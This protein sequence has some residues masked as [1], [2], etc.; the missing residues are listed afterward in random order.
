MCFWR[1]LSPTLPRA[2]LLLREAG[3]LGA[4]DMSVE[5]AKRVDQELGDVAAFGPFRLFP[6]ARL[7]KR[8]DVPVE[9]GGRA[10][11]ILI[12]LVEEAGKVVSKADLLA[13]IWRDITVVEGV[14]RTHVCS[15][16][17]ALGDVA[18][19]TRYITSV[20]GRGYC[21]VAPVVRST[22][23]VTAETVV[24]A[25]SEGGKLS[26]S[27]PPRLG[28]MA[29]RDE[30]VRKL[31]E[32]LLEHRFVT[33]VGAAGIGKTTVAVS[34]GHALLDNFGG[35]VRF[36]ELGSIIDPN[37][38]AATVASTL[39][40]VV[41]TDDALPSLQAFL[42]DKRVLIVLDNCEHLVAAAATLSEHL[43]LHAPHVHLLATSREAL[44]V[45]GER[46]H[47][48]GPLETPSV[49]E[50]MSAEAV[51]TFPAVQVLLERAAAGGWFADLTDDDV[52]FVAQICNRLDGV[53]LALELGAS[54]VGEC[55]LRGTAAMLDDRSR[56]L[57][58]HGRRTAPPR[59]QTLHALIAWSYDRLSK[60]ECLV[61]RRLS[62]MVGAF[63]LDT[64]KAVVLDDGDPCESFPEVISGLVAKSL[65]SSSVE[66]GEVV[67][68]MLETTR[69]FAFER[70]D[71]SN[72]LQQ[73]SLRHAL[74]FEER[75]ARE[76]EGR[77]ATSH[78]QASD[79]GNVRAALV[80][81]FS[82]PSGTGA[83][84]RLAS[85]AAQVLLK[86]GLVSECHHWC[87]QALAVMAPPE[88]GTLIE[89]RLQE[90]LAHSAIFTRGLDSDAGTA[91]TRGLEL[92]RALG[93]GD[94]EIRLLGH[95][96]IFLIMAGDF[97]EGLEV[98]RQCE[99]VGSAS[100]AGVIIAQS[101]IGVAEGAC[102]NTLRSQEHC[103]ESLRRAVQFGK[104][105]SMPTAYTN[106]RLTLARTFWLR[107][108]PARAAALAR[109]V[110]SDSATLTHA[111]DKCLRLA[112][113]ETIFAWCG[114]WSEADRLLD[115]LAEHVERYSLASHRGMALGL[116]G[117]FLVK[118]DQPRQGCSLLR[119]AA[120]DLK[121]TKNTALDTRFASALAEGLAATGSIDE[122]LATVQ[123]ALELAQRRG[124]TWDG[125][126]LLRLK[127][128]LLASG[129]GKDPRAADETLARA[130]E[131]ARHQG[132]VAWE[133]RAA[134]EIAREKLRRG[135][136][137]NDLRD[138]AA[139]YARFTDGFQTPDLQA[140]HNLL[141]PH[142]RSDR[143]R[144]GSES[145]VVSF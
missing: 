115:M 127:G 21:F 133:L 103:E 8:D 123:A 70:L 86:L 25:T 26:P 23:E 37:L 108:Q 116:R 73:V 27:L 110:M 126:D 60:W 24:P 83:G 75:L 53:A 29:G 3:R 111:V 6:A 51:Q 114:E 5:A 30:T 84:V 138:L 18:S 49:Y 54:F 93:G 1:D 102:G 36:I 2:G 87:R 57:W 79:L 98:A 143:Q 33:V 119:N 15:L 72:E 45:E 4:K 38:V 20:A 91:L 112:Y 61:L 88:T 118:T 81:C 68:R 140:A 95:L 124:G 117:E 129:P 46:V 130:V 89:L 55:G 52:P 40:I 58:Q 13:S 120:A 77:E 121:V 7:L 12:A 62:V 94:N 134:T 90:A 105:R 64:A 28:R 11:D 9:L 42:R 22:R 17:K 135:G 67:Y 137:A 128:V 44:R 78:G 14:L 63:A 16:R 39:G 99:R 59:Q 132:S 142:G 96:T 97:R 69:V 43:F 47:R 85:A 56:V 48:L 65:L 104:V 125:P 101:T 35:A 76:A 31:I 144:R 141:E 92:A 107:G 19:G 80:R 139:V 32:Q 109:E 71:E 82:S 41:Q 34:L 131:L 100:T 136:C 145:G 10:L 113:C 66:D 50:G 106:A 74:F 122:A